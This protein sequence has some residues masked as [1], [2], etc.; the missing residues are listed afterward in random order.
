MAA[1]VD[2]GDPARVRQHVFLLP[3]KRAACPPAC[4]G[5]EA[6]GARPGAR[7]AEAG[8]R[9]LRTAGHLAGSH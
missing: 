9:R 4:A 5:A 2:C 1:G 3:G 6:R 7:G 8:A